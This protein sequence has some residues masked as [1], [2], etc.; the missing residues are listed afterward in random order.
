MNNKVILKGKYRL[1]G[2]VKYIDELPTN[3]KVGEVYLVSYMGFSDE[4]GTNVINSIMQYTKTGWKTI[5]DNSVASTYAIINHQ[6]KNLIFKDANGL[7]EFIRSNYK[8]DIPVNKIKKLY[9]VQ[10]CKDEDFR[11]IVYFATPRK[12][13][14]EYVTELV[15]LKCIENI[16]ETKD[17]LYDW[18]M[19]ETP[20]SIDDMFKGDEMFE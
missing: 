10:G 15:R 2:Y 6:Q 19:K 7:A 16:P 12:T 9:F 3:C 4:K 14:L 13:E 17:R 11:T 18:S 8:D 20:D 1:T 5:D